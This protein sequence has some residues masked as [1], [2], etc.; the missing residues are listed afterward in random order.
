MPPLNTTL[1][2]GQLDTTT[3]M[4]LQSQ[5]GQSPASNNHQFIGVLNKKI[6]IVLF[7]IY[8]GCLFAEVTHVKAKL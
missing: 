1:G 6:V 4:M 3:S 8:E 7:N 2:N 5:S